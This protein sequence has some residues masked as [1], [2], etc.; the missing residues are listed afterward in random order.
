MSSTKEDSTDCFYSVFSPGWLRLCYLASNT[1]LAPDNTESFHQTWIGLLLKALLR[2]KTTSS[3]SGGLSCLLSQTLLCNR[4]CGPG[5]ILV[6]LGPWQKLQNPGIT[7]LS[8]LPV[9]YTELGGHTRV[10]FLSF[11]FIYCLPWLVLVPMLF[12]PAL[13]CQTDLNH[14]EH[15]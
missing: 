10:Q 1:W 5:Q 15:H 7:L 9:H 8:I 2:W 11:L 13:W 3:C 14:Q 6:A 4:I 12:L